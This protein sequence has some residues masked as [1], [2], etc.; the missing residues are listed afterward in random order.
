MKVTAIRPMQHGLANEGILQIERIASGLGVII[1]SSATKIAA[2][3]HILRGEAQGQIPENPAY[4]ADTGL[5]F[6]LDE[7]KKQGALSPYSVAIAGG[8][9]M[10]A[11]GSKESKLTAT[12]KELLAGLK[13]QVKLE[14]TGGAQVRAMALNIDTGKIRIN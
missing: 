6:L 4:Y 9:S 7:L 5:S 8:S 10:L 2:G 13:L 14:Q 1:F 12:V 11:N 3:I